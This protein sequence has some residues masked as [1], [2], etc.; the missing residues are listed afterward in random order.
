ME[1]AESPPTD[2]APL[3]EAASD[4]ASYPGLLTDDAAKEFLDRFP[5]T[6]LFSVLQSWVDRPGAEATVVACL[7]RLFRTKYGASLL[8]QYTSFLQAGLRANSHTLRCLACKSVSYILE[9]AEDRGTIVKTI[10]GFDIYSLL[11]DCLIEG[12][13]ETSA[14]ALGAIKNIVQSPEGIDVIFPAST[15]ESV[16]L[17]HVA[18][19]CSSLGRIRVLALIKELFSLSSS[20]AS[21]VHKA[22]LLKLFEAEIN[23]RDDMLTTLSALELLYELVE[24]PHSS[25]FLSKVTLLHILADMISDAGIDSVLRSRACLISGRL[26][27]LADAHEELDESITSL[28]LAIDGRLKLLE[29]Q[30]SDEYESAIEALGQIGASSQGAIL[31]LTSSSPVARHVF[32]AVFGHQSRGKQLAALHALG[33]ICGAS[34]PGDRMLLNNAAEKCLRQLFYAAAAN[35]PKMTPSG[36]LLWVLQQEPEKRQAGYRLISA[37]V[38][39]PWGLME[40][41]SKQEI[42]TIVTDANIE[43]TKFGM[44]ARFNCCAAINNALS[45]S[46]MLHDASIAEVA[47]KLQDAVRRG[48]YLAKKRIEAQPVVVTADRF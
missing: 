37:L 42:I 22:N 4:F 25:R 18:S 46:N 36:L 21:A 41:C 6:F 26:L 47:A 3:L 23:N 9:N 45:A 13:E 8:L 34:R 35:S 2:L 14:A 11:V 32:Q 5:L 29:G 27:S 10:V 39:R 30:D 31:L 20:V 43:D 40:V 24:S 38:A 19:R 16:H 17:E 33:D 12:N 7:D 44:E 28:L 48:P 15:Q 1:T